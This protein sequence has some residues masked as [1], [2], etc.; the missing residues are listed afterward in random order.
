MIQRIGRANGP[1]PSEIAESTLSAVE[2]GLTLI[3][4][5]PDLTVERTRNGQLHL[6]RAGGGTRLVLAAQGE[7]LILRVASDRVRH[8][9]RFTWS[10]EEVRWTSAALP[11]LFEAV[12]GLLERELYADREIGP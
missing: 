1:R 9:H 5:L 8:V 12:C 3:D 7:Q 6:Q 2:R 4:S 11:E 10:A